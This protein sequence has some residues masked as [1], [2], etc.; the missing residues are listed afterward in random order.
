MCLLPRKRLTTIP[1]TFSTSHGH[2]QSPGLQAPMATGTARGRNSSSMICKCG[3]LLIWGR[4][5][6]WERGD[7]LYVSTY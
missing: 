5:D 4:P 2:R 1:K 7:G 3:V 6:K